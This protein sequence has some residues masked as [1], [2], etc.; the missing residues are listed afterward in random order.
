MMSGASIAAGKSLSRAG[1]EVMADG[2]SWAFAETDRA[3]PTHAA[4]K[5]LRFVILATLSSIFIGAQERNDGPSS[6]RGLHSTG[7]HHRVESLYS[8]EGT[9]EEDKPLPFIRTFPLKVRP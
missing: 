9:I 4:Y 1:S 2:S 5:R 6:W 8:C 3:S 7:I